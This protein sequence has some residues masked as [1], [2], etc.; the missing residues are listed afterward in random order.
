LIKKVI[1]NKAA[2]GTEKLVSGKTYQQSGKK[3]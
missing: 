3:W 2:L 1:N